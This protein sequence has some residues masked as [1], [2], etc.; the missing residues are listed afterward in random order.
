MLQYVPGQLHTGPHQYYQQGPGMYEQHYYG[1]SGSYSQFPPTAY[2]VGSGPERFASVDQDSRSGYS[3]AV[4]T[5]SKRKRAQ[6]AEHPQSTKLVLDP[7]LQAIRKFRQGVV[8]A[9]LSKENDKQENESPVPGPSASDDTEMQE[10]NATKVIQQ[11]QSLNQAKNFEIQAKYAR[12]RELEQQQAATKEQEAAFHRQLSSQSREVR[13]LQQELAQLRA[14]FDSRSITT[15]KVGDRVLALQ[16]ELAVLGESLKVMS[17]DK[18][19]SNACGNARQT[20]APQVTA[21]A[22]VAE[23]SN[24]RQTGTVQA[25][26]VRSPAVQSGAVQPTAQ[27]TGAVEAPVSQAPAVPSDRAR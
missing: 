3:D 21:Q 14:E 13:D 25:Q 22:S 18:I 5:G 16:R 1:D 24:A 15:A 26:V 20:N 12:I 27:Q 23:K 17:E 6:H 10:N 11:L 8:K 9:H 4:A 19:A 2:P 7:G